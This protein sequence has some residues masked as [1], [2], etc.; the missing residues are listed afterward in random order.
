MILIFVLSRLA[1]SLL[2]LP[3]LILSP[4][5]SHTF[6]I[7]RFTS[8]TLLI[9]SE[10]TAVGISRS[11]AIFFAIESTKAVL[12][13]AGRAAMIT[14]SGDCQPDV[15][16]SKAWNP[17][18]IPEIEPVFIAA[19]SIRLKAS[20]ITGSIC[21]T[22][23]FCERCEISKIPASAVCISSSTSWVSSKPISSICAASAITSRAVAF[24]AIIS[25]W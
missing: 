22:S 14:R 5:S 21:V 13:I 18:G 23:R 9:S 20:S 17:E 4:S 12:P 15:I 8:C 16:L 25:A 10:K 19:F 7:R 1:S 2:I 24:F 6:M 3:V 11:I